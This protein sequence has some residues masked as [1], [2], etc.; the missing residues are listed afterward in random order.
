M[1]QYKDFTLDPV[2]FSAP[3]VQSFIK[4]IH[5]K[6]IHYGRENKYI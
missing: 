5:S 3:D 2:R 1:L 6:G 4:D